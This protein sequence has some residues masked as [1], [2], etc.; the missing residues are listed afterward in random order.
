M[1]Q[2]KMVSRNVAIA[3]GVVC[4][5]LIAGL[6]GA[7]AYYTMTINDKDNQINSANNTINQF[8]ATIADQNNTI[9]SLNTQLAIFQNQIRNIHVTGTE[10][11][12]VWVNNQTRTGSEG[13]VWDF[14]NVSSAGYVLILV[15]SNY[16]STIA[17][18]AYT[19]KNLTLYDY[20]TN[21]GFGGIA[22]FPVLPTYVVI[23]EIT[24]SES[25]TATVT[26]IYCY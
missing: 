7:M 21:V 3:L 15:S 12:T 16:N 10:N 25:S 8:N 9:F 11:S 24:F 22:V 4:I 14:Y 5:L 13:G 2:K 18:I 6:G 23:V 19:S 26:A 17:E 1:S 20:Q